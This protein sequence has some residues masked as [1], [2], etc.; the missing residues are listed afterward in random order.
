MT[1]AEC[2][3]NNVQF[4]SAR[5][6][7]WW[8]IIG[9]LASQR[10]ETFPDLRLF[11]LCVIIFKDY[12]SSWMSPNSH[13]WESNYSVIV[14]FVPTHTRNPNNCLFVRSVLLDENRLPVPS[15]ITNRGIS[16]I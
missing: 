13:W 3:L 9:N 7:D 1:S 4:D 15:G 2:G 11:F 12:S 8:G 14:T 16:G 10:R 5:I 6:G